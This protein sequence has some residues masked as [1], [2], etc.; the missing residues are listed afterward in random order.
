MQLMHCNS[1]F[2]KLSLTGSWQEEVNFGVLGAFNNLPLISELVEGGFGS[3]LAPP[4]TQTQQRQICSEDC[5]VA[6]DR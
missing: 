4:C 1:L 6:P 2:Q 3:S 5:F